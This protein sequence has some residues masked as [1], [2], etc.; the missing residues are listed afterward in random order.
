MASATEP[1][2]PASYHGPFAAD[3]R[4]TVLH[5]CSAIEGEGMPSFFA[6][7]FGGRQPARVGQF[8]NPPA[9]TDPSYGEHARQPRTCR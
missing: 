9:I 6:E 8:V 3:V 2:G 1:H 5:G 4:R 7:R